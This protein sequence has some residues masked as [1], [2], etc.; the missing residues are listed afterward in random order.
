MTKNGVGRAGG[1]SAVPAEGRCHMKRDPRVDPRPGDVVRPK[2]RN[3][4]TVQWG[5]F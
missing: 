2:D 4:R 1:R 3:T 5:W